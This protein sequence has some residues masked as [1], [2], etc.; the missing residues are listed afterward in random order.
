MKSYSRAGSGGHHA[1][2]WWFFAPAEPGGK[3]TGCSSP[4]AKRREAPLT[5]WRRRIQCKSRWAGQVL[6]AC[7]AH[8]RLFRLRRRLHVKGWGEKGNIGARSVT[9]AKACKCFI[10]L[11]F[12]AGT[13]KKTRNRHILGY[14]QATDDGA[15]PAPGAARPPGPCATRRAW[16]RRSVPR[17]LHQQRGRR[18]RTSPAWRLTA[19]RRRRAA[20]VPVRPP[21]PLA[22]MPYGAVGAAAGG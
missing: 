8:R 12:V 14:I 20:T 15:V 13:V 11:A 2:A 1:Q 21:E 17:P 19:A 5:G 9:K 6:C 10:C 3:K 22:P 4:P 16:P 7:V 18:D